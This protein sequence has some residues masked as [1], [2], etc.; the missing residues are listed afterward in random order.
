VTLIDAWGPGH[1]RASSGGETRIIRAT[2]GSRAV[3][4]SMAMRALELWRAHDERFRSRLFHETG[5]LWMFGADDGFGRAS[6]QVLSDHGAPL[7]ALTRAEAGRRYPQ[8]QFDGVSSILFEPEAGYLHARRA[9]RDVVDIL[10]AEGG[11]YRPGSVALPVPLGTDSLRQVLLND[12]SGIDADAFVF[13][14]GP[15]LPVMFP[16]ILG[17]V[18]T[19]TRQEVYYF[20]PP[21]GTV[22][23]SDGRLP[24]WIDMTARQ[25]YGIPAHGSSGFKVADDTTGPAIDP[26]DIDRVPTPEG[27]AAARGFLARRFPALADA[28]LVAAEVCQYESS[29]DASFII[30]RHPTVSNVWIAGGGSGHG[31]KMGP[32]V[33]ELM[34]RLVLGQSSPEPHFGVARFAAPPPGGWQT[35]WS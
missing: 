25:I 31:F 15:W 32:A 24:V 23:F 20:G 35:R 30:D 19:A 22:A 16:D 14:C 7:E 21:A 13:A 5:V 9:C 17:D 12:G 18:L 10:C 6:A 11:E 26:T 34:A 8:I 29:R 4:T 2:Y 1:D 28:P 27:V 3:Y 33:G